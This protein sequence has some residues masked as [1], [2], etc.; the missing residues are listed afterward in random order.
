MKVVVIAGPTAVGKT[1]VAIRVAEVLSGEIVSC[2]SM[3][4][5]KYMDIGSA[6]PDA[7]ELARV[8]HHLIGAVDPREP[9]SVVKYRALAMDAVRDIHD[10][11]KL[12]V[13]CGGTGLYLDALLYELDFAGI[14]ESD[15]SYREELYKIAETEG[16]EALH[17]MLESLDP[18]SAARI[19]PNNI[20]RIVRAIESAASGSP[21]EDFGRERT[22]TPEIDPILIGLS[23]DRTELY[24]RINRRVDIMLENGLVDEVRSLMELGLTDSDISMKGIGYKEVIAYLEDRCSFD[25]MRDNIMKNTRHYAKRQMTWFKRYKDMKWFVLS[26]ENAEERAASEILEWLSR[27]L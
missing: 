11:G 24:D 13:I 26:G 16:P 10:R 12:P 2:D 18:E 14:P 23:R 20:K 25:E 21:I 6:K 3:Q 4:L 9:F 19:H 15:P 8:P 17:A 27:R 5:Y 22:V 1:D 7:Q